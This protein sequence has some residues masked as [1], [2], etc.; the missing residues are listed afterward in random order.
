MD[1]LN[2]IK[3]LPKDKFGMILFI[4]VTGLFFAYKVYMLFNARRLKREKEAKDEIKD[5]QT[6]QSDN[7]TIEDQHA[8]DAGTLRDRMR[9]NRS[10]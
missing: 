1:V 9:R 6:N 4:I 8:Q 3:D 10:E 2:Q 5:S 7:T